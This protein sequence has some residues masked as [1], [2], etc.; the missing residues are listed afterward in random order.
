MKNNLI[1]MNLPNTSGTLCNFKSTHISYII[2]IYI[3][4]YMY[5]YIYIVSIVFW[6]YLKYWVEETSYLFFYRKY[7]FYL[8]KK[9][10]YWNSSDIQTGKAFATTQKFKGEAMLYKWAWITCCNSDEGLKIKILCC[11]WYYY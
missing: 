1:K 3:Y 6:T 11:P 5:V 10:L 9:V 8:L 7:S 2:Y 4:I